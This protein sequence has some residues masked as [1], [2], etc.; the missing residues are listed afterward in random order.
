MA[1]VSLLQCPGMSERIARVRQKAEAIW[2]K[3]LLRQYTDHTIDHSRRVI[4]VLDKLCALLVEPLTDDE[5]YVLLCA[6]FLHDIGMQQEKFFETDVV[7]KRYSEEEIAEAEADRAKGEAI[8]REWHYLISEE[9]IKYE[10]GDKYMEEE[11]IDEIALVSKGHTKE[12]L[13]GYKDGTKAGQPMRLRLLAALLRLADEL[14]LDY[15]RV[16]LDELE[17]AIILDESK[18]HWWKCY[19]STFR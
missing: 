11:F 19:Y 10:L 18:A 7:R 13:D 12:D 9:R 14:D 4:A 2:K 8:I 16:D 6:A 3:P 5:P 17:Q 15:P 1:N